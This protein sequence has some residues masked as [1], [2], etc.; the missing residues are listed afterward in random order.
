MFSHQID[1]TANY[2]DA[3]YDVQGFPTIKFFP[4]GDKTEVLPYEG[5]RTLDDIIEFVS[6][7]SN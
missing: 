4:A 3:A 5:T 2:I 6:A 7:N 1:A